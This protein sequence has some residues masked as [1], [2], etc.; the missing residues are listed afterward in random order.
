MAVSNEMLALALLVDATADIAGDEGR[1]IRDARAAQAR[2]QQRAVEIE[3]Q[4]QVEAMSAATRDRRSRLVHL[5]SG[6]LAGFVAGFAILA[7]LNI[8]GANGKTLGEEF[9][10]SSGWAVIILLVGV[11]VGVAFGGYD[12][13]EDFDFLETVIECGKWGGPLVAL[14]VVLGVVMSELRDDSNVF[15]KF[16]VVLINGGFGGIGGALVGA[17]FFGAVGIVYATV[18]RITSALAGTA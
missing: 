7:I 12:C 6:G 9:G 17:I 13:S 14:C 4:R 5:G 16:F 2:Q 11:G 18:R 8:N 10:I 15:E 3:R 1:R